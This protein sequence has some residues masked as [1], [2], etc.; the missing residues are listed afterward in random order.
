MQGLFFAKMDCL[1]KK[2]KQNLEF[3][4]KTRVNWSFTNLGP[5]GHNL[6]RIYAK[7]KNKTSK[8]CN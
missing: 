8:D 7:V 6:I 2:Y 3:L 5:K 4:Q 1:F